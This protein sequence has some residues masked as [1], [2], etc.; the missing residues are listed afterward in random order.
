MVCHL[1]SIFDPN[2]FQTMLSNLCATIRPLLIASTRSEAPTNLHRRAK[3]DH[4]SW[5]A[6]APLSAPT[7]RITE[8]RPHNSLYLAKFTNQFA[9]R[10][11]QRFPLVSVAPTARRTSIYNIQ[12]FRCRF[13]QGYRLHHRNL[14]SNMDS[15]IL[16]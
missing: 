6:W 12:H 4:A 7:A 8:Y 3:G 10:G 9:N 15:L 1:K 11:S 13:A 14:S 5:R 2:A 16:N